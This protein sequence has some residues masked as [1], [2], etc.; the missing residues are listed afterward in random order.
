[1]RAVGDQPGHPC[2]RKLTMQP[3]L[4]IRSTPAEGEEGKEKEL[5]V[6][7]LTRLGLVP[8]LP[9]WEQPSCERPRSHL[10]EDERGACVRS[11]ISSPVRAKPGVVPQPGIQRNPTASRIH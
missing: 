2:K 10:E 4:P 9:A 8:R 6:E 1:M 7:Y 11:R 3:S 5:T